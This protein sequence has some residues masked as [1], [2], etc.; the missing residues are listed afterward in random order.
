MLDAC[1]AIITAQSLFGTSQTR[2]LLIPINYLLTIVVV[3]WVV[4]F[5]GPPVESQGETAS[6]SSVVRE[7]NQPLRACPL[8]EL[9]S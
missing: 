8:I 6:A 1:I 3:L 5:A 2:I 9:P 7:E 4:M